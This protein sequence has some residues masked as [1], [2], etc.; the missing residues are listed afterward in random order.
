MNKFVYI[1]VDDYQLHMAHFVRE[2]ASLRENTMELSNGL[3][4]SRNDL[5]MLIQVVY[6]HE[7]ILLFLHLYTFLYDFQ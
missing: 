1:L 2:L 4:C 5:D 7:L 3:V 6:I